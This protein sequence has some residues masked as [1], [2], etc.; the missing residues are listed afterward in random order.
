MTLMIHEECKRFFWQI[1][2]HF[3]YLFDQCGFSVVHE[4]GDGE[5][6][7][8]VI[9]SG[10]CQMEFLYDKGIVEISVGTSQRRYY[11]F[12][13]I[14]FV[15]GKQRPTLEEIDRIMEL[16]WSGRTDDGLR[17]VSKMLKPV[18]REVVELFQE[19]TFSKRQNE[20]D[21]FYRAIAKSLSEGDVI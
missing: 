5:H 16:F 2:K 20:L 4:D 10:S 12:W 11:I 21:E 15:K 19:K 13:V 6:C 9:Q 17:T 3:D 8:I 18:C 14:K 7:L 1:K